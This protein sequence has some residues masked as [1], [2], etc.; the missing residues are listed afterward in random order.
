MV[1]DFW[2]LTAK[3]HLGKGPIWE[4]DGFK[5]G[6]LNGEGCRTKGK[7]DTQNVYQHLVVVVQISKALKL[8][9]CIG[10]QQPLVSYL[11]SKQV[12]AVR[13]VFA[14]LRARYSFV[15]GPEAMLHDQQNQPNKTHCRTLP[16][17]FIVFC[18]LTNRTC[19]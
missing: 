3:R 12:L 9:N 14:S 19:R 8:R 11:V 17:P 4:S 13:L 2:A 6:V 18:L 7:R 1:W 15:L 16:S 5:I 10:Q